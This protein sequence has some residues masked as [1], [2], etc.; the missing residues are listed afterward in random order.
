MR[1][2]NIH[3]GRRNEVN[4][5]HASA[6]KGGGI[7]FKIKPDF[8]HPY[9]FAFQ[10]CRSIPKIKNKTYSLLQYSHD[11]YCICSSSLLLKMKNVETTS[12]CI[13]DERMQKTFSVRF[14]YLR[15]RRVDS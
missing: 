5:D 4:R 12:S 9:V 10:H 14:Q 11:C 6:Q 7:L 1:S 15:K 13:I 8:V 2:H 3:S